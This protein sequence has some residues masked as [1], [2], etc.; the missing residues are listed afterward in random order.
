MGIATNLCDNCLPN[1]HLRGSYRGSSLSLAWIPAKKHA[2]MTNSDR[3]RNRLYRH[4]ISNEERN[5][6]P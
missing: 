5:L 6:C 2:G 3:T 1:R 4:V